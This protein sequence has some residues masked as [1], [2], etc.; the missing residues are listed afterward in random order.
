M[1]QCVT[2]SHEVTAVFL[3]DPQCQP[4]THITTPL[5]INFART[6]NMLCW[7]VPIVKRNTFATCQRNIPSETFFSSALFWREVITQITLL[8]FGV[9]QEGGRCLVNTTSETFFLLLSIFRTTEFEA[10]ALAG[11]KIHQT[12]LKLAETFSRDHFLSCCDVATLIFYS[13]V[14]FQLIWC[15]KNGVKTHDW[16]PFAY[17]F[18]RSTY[19]WINYMSI[20]KKKKVPQKICMKSAWG[21]QWRATAAYFRQ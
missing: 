18:I 17:R 10:H 1:H 7:R 4:P 14:W 13:V 2:V 3:S 15:S 21:W 11:P 20:V 12:A 9:L 8:L 5:L 6:E 16:Q 19:S